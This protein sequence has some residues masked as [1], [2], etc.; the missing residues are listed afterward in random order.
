MSAM[1]G[2]RR[3]VLA[4]VAMAGMVIVSSAPAMAQGGPNEGNVSVS[5]GIDATNAYMF[6][7]IYQDDTKLITWPYAEMGLELFSGDGGLKSVGITLGTWNSLHPGDAGSDGPSGKLWYESDFYAGFGLGFGGGVSLD[8][9]FTAYTSPNTAFDTV[10]EISFQVGVDDSAWLGRGALQPH[11]LV[12]F[13]LGEAAADGH[14]KGI[15]LELGVAPGIEGSR[16]SLSFPVKVGLSLRDFYEIEIADGIV[17]DNTFGYV[18]VSAVV[19]VP[20]SSIP[21]RFGSWSIQGGVEL[22]RL[23][24]TTKALNGGD[25]SR[26]MGLFG[27]GLSY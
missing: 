3:H 4:L 6:R 22:Q 5:V 1:S 10:K 13:E 16:A 7:G 18:S 15:Y 12:A 14:H 17:E 25:A 21:A 20:L 19:A 27:V 23:G 2:V 9:T 24:T 8:T 11:A 26:V